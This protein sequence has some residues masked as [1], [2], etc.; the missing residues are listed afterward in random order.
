MI[1]TY[2]PFEETKCLDE[3]EKNH[4][5]AE[6]YKLHP[7]ERPADFVELPDPAP[8]PYPAPTQ[9]VIKA[10]KLTF[11]WLCEIEP[12]FKKLVIEAASADGK[13]PDYSFS[14]SWLG[15]DGLKKRA[16]ELVRQTALP[17]E[18]DERWKVQEMVDRCLYDLLPPD[19]PDDAQPRPD[20]NYLELAR[21]RW[22]ACLPQGWTVELASGTP[23][24]SPWA[25]VKPCARQVK[26]FDSYAA[27]HRSSYEPCQQAPCKLYHHYVV[28]QP[29][30]RT[31]DQ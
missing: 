2:S 10:D 17:I 14:A 1:K 22:K 31:H 9:P 12:E 3:Y 26:L 29:Y 27:A 21:A 28:E 24:T 5:Q 20:E 15:R 25:D 11:A 16:L 19:P 18:E 23:Y 13:S 4:A 30:T 7:D 8:A 6:H